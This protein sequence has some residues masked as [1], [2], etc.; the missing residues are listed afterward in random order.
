MIMQE[1]KAALSRIGRRITR[2][3]CPECG[4]TMILVEQRNEN[5][6]MFEW[7]SCNRHNCTGQWLRKISLPSS[8]IENV[9]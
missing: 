9:A 7:Y 2:Q 6:V 4:N 5:G 1:G 8:N 3:R